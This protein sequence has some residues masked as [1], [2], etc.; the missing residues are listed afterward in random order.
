MSGY[1]ICHIHAFCQRIICE[2]EKQNRQDEETLSD[3]LKKRLGY[4]C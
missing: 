1:D 4:L 2:Y 3:G